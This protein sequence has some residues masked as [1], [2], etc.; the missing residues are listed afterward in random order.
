M[1]MNKKRIRRLNSGI[2][3]PQSPDLNPVEHLWTVALRNL[4]GQVFA[5]REALWL[6]L[7]AAFAAIPAST[8][9]SLYASM[10][11]RIVAVRKARGGATRY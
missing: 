7:Q 2:W 5:G 8:I 3:P 6:A 1:W 9:L 10:P 4:D 11:R